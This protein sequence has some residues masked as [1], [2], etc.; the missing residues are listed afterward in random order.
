[1]SAGYTTDVDLLINSGYMVIDHIAVMTD[2]LP[3]GLSHCL[4]IFIELLRNQ[5]LS[6][7]THPPRYDRL[8]SKAPAINGDLLEDF[9]VGNGR[10]ALAPTLIG[11]LPPWTEPHVANP[12]AKLAP[13]PDRS[14]PRGWQ[15]RT[16]SP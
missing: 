16:A 14:D 10:P 11:G 3:G 7:E 12:A 15:C 4:A 6:A 1:M 2:P 5:P 13:Q 8:G 9:Q